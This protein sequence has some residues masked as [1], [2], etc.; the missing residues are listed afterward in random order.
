MRDPSSTGGG[1][2]R[3][4]NEEE[5]EVDLIY[6]RC[7]SSPRLRWCRGCK[8]TITIT[9]ERRQIYYIPYTHSECHSSHPCDLT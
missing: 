1:G 3:G 7:T 9:K 6:T 5:E 2:G 4:G 8:V